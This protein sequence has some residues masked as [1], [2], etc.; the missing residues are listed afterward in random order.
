MKILFSPSE[1]KRAGGI[2]KPFDQNSFI[3]PE[4]YSRRK[5]IVDSYHKIIETSNDEILSK[6]FGIKNPSKFIQYRQNI[7]SQPTMK[8][9][10]RYCG[11]AFEYLDYQT[12]SNQEKSYIDQ[13]TMIFSNLFGPIL[14]GDLAL[15]EYKLK[16][17]EKLDNFVIE[18]F[19]KEY[20]S[21]AIDDWLGDKPFIDLRAG[22]Y[23]KFYKTTTKEYITLKFLKN[24]KV[25][26]HWAK[27]YR[28]LVLR[29]LAQNSIK[30]IDDF[31][32]MNISGV[33]I[34]E[35]IKI[36]NMTQINFNIFH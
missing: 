20:F 27:A 9:I 31:M 4:L 10:E 17:G 34:N 6:L 35:I 26:S 14:A 18:R 7:Y 23:N 11:V 30:N 13:N 24:G 19:Y 8:T 28:G 2:Q 1:A 29:A 22:F 5:E 36:K 12:L 32:N 16:Q 33:K 15:P 25:V 3:F 21:N